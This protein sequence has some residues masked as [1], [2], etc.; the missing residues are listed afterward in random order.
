ML[1][2]GICDAYF[3]GGGKSNIYKNIFTF[4]RETFTE[5]EKIKYARFGFVRRNDEKNAS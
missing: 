2:Y 3:P 1:L 5:Q 4:L